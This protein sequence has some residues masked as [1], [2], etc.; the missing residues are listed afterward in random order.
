MLQKYC[1]VR[2]PISRNFLDPSCKGHHFLFDTIGGSAPK[3]RSSGSVSQSTR[4]AFRWQRP[5][6]LCM[7]FFPVFYL[8]PC[9]MRSVIPQK[10]TASVLGT[11]LRQNQQQQRRNHRYW[12]TKSHTPPRP[13]H[14][15]TKLESTETKKYRTTRST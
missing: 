7:I 11:E 5:Q 12:S 8:L 4:S 3:M 14:Q 1:V 9:Q 10:R 13:P 2:L 6:G 15:E